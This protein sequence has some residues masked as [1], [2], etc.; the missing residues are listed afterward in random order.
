MSQIGESEY[1]KISGQFEEKYG[2]FP[3]QRAYNYTVDVLTEIVA[4]YFTVNDDRYDH[5][6]TTFLR[7]NMGTWKNRKTEY[8]TRVTIIEFVGASGFSNDRVQ[9][10]VCEFVAMLANRVTHENVSLLDI[11]EKIGFRYGMKDIECN[12]IKGVDFKLKPNGNAE[13]K[14]SKEVVEY[15]NSKL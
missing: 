14:L 1:Y 15:L 13:L 9:H 4:K 10:D 3:D 11:K 12:L 8:K 7:R 6:P 2:K 5:I